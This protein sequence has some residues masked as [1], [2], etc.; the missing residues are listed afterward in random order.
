MSFNPFEQKPEKI[1]NTFYDWK[2]LYLKPYSKKDVSSYTKLRIILMNGTEFE[3]NW[4]THAFSRSCLN[5][6]IR[7]ELALMRRSEQQQQKRISYL[8]PIDENIL[9]T[10]IGY[11]HLAVD[12]TAILAMKEPDIYVKQALDFALLEDY[13]HLYRY[14]NLLDLEYGIKA[15]NLINKYVEIM[16]GRP[17][18]SEHRFPHDDIRRYITSVKS[19]PLTKLAVGIITAA[20]QQTM[21]FYM[22]VGPTYTTD[23]GRK[24]YSEIAMIEEQHVTHYGGLM[25]TSCTMLQ[26]LLMHQYTECY[27]YY[28][29]Y[30]DETDPK[31][32]QIWEQHLQQEIAHLHLAKEMLRTYDGI[33][34]QKVIPDGQFPDLLKFGPTIDYVREVLQTVRLTSNKEDYANVKDLPDDHRYFKYQNQVNKNVK[35]VPSHI[36][37][38]DYAISK[39][40]SDYR[41]ETKQHP[42]DSLRDRVK[43]NTEIG[44][45]KQA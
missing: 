10:T 39:T 22:N 2:N 8:K 13:D 30:E 23:I 17:T 36:I 3:Q 27:L 15:E 34:W 41:F 14:A 24:L 7:R 43:D 33:E 1:E 40:G 9:E 5:N 18:I 21:N 37:I 16:P 42:I 25:D 4:F 19:D 45:N 26:H 32:K 20:E 29:C 6:D 35:D 12:L 44:R 38:N 28:S 31:I 11:E